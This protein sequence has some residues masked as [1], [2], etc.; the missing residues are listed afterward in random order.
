MSTARR[1]PISD[2]KDGSHPRNIRPSKRVARML[3]RRAEGSV[4]DDDE[5]DEGTDVKML[6]VLTLVRSNETASERTDHI[7][8]NSKIQQ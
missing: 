8:R 3:G 1:S 6:T 4:M 2:E 5:D 7:T